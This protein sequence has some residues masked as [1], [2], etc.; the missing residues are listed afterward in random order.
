[1]SSL[2]NWARDRDYDDEHGALRKH[3]LDDDLCAQRFHIALNNGEAQAHSAVPA[4]TRVR[5]L[6]A[7]FECLRDHRGLDAGSRVAN[8]QFNCGAELGRS[9]EHTSELQSR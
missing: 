2:G 8:F 4:D 7:A 3:G 5:K 6:S 1:M 9:E